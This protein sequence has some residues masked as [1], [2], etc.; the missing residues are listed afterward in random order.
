MPIGNESAIYE[1]SPYL[2][3]MSGGGAWVLRCFVVKAAVY[4]FW[5]RVVLDMC[6]CSGRRFILIDGDVMKSNEMLIAAD[7][8]AHVGHMGRRGTF[9]PIS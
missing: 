5:T 9:W 2:E 4:L 3:I 1:P 6:D 7:P 8:V